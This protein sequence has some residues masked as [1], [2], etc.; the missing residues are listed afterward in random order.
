MLP[1]GEH[2]ESF[3]LR[4]PSERRGSILILGKGEEDQSFLLRTPS[5]RSGRRITLLPRYLARE[6]RLRAA[7]RHRREVDLIARL[8]L[9]ANAAEQTA[10]AAR[11]RAAEL[12][13]LAVADVD[14]ALAAVGDAAA[15]LPRDVRL[16]ELRRDL[17]RERDVVARLEDLRRVVAPDAPGVFRP[18]PLA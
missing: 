3:L 14:R 6:A 5:E 18:V 15:L 9:A 13:E 2:D 7:L 4:T 11:A 8:W 16:L 10:A 12:A 1:R 17:A